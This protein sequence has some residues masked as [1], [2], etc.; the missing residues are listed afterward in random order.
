MY[1]HVPPQTKE[2][3]KMFQG[4]KRSRPD[5]AASVH[6]NTKCCEARRQNSLECGLI[7]LVVDLDSGCR[8]M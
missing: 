5:W 4:T 6:A 7:D 2:S 8:T 1:H 3:S